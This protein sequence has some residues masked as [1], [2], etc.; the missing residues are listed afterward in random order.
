MKA[1]QQ[2]IEAIHNGQ[3][4]KVKSLLEQNP[5]LAHI[6]TDKGLSIIQLAAYLRESALINLLL[7]YKKELDI[8]EA[9]ATGQIDQV[10]NAFIHT[11][12]L[13]GSFS[14]DGFT[15]LGLASFFGHVGVVKWLLAKGANVDVP[16]KNGFEVRP[17]HSAVASKH[18]DIAKL[19]IEAGADVNAPQMSGI[20]PIHSAAHNADIAMTR[21]LLNHGADPTLTTEDGKTALDLAEGETIALLQ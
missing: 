16:S 15:P 18:L 2:I 6:Q 3:L 19:L 21:L 7:S 4:E 20:R 10:Q 17:L 5:D 1:Q 9:A 8:F 11:P 12:S 14:S 13:I